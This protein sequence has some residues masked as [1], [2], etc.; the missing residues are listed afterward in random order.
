MRRSLGEIAAITGGVLRGAD[1]RLT[2]ASS[3]S[4]EVRAG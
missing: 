3:D 2:G 4:R 1:V